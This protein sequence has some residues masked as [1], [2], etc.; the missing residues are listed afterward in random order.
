VPTGEYIAE[1]I[2]VHNT[3]VRSRLKSRLTVE[4]SG[5]S[6][7]IFNF[8]KNEGVLYGLIAIAA[9]LVAGW[10]GGVAFRKI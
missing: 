5:L 9:A 6:A 8:A 7:K 1:T 2:L 4:K 10:I 3:E